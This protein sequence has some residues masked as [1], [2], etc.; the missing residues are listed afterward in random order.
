MASDEFKSADDYE[1]EKQHFCDELIAEI[2]KYEAALAKCNDSESFNSDDKQHSDPLQSYT[3]Q[4]L[5]DRINNL[6]QQIQ[7]LQ[8][9]ENERDLINDVDF[10]KAPMTPVRLMLEFF[11]PSEQLDGFK[12]VIIKAGT[13]PIQQQLAPLITNTD[14]QR[15]GFPDEAQQQL[16][17]LL[18]PDAA[19]NDVIKFLSVLT[20]FN[21]KRVRVQNV[22]LSQWNEEQIPLSFMIYTA[23][24]VMQSNEQKD[25]EIELRSELTDSDAIWVFIHFLRRFCVDNQWNGIKLEEFWNSVTENEFG[26]ALAEGVCSHFE[27]DI[28]RFTT[29]SNMLPNWYDD[30]LRRL[31]THPVELAECSVEDIVTLLTYEAS[32]DRKESEYGNE[33]I[34]GVFSRFEKSGVDGIECLTEIE[35]WKE[36]IVEWMRSEEMDGKELTEMG[37][38]DMASELSTALMPSDVTGF[39]RKTLKRALKEHLCCILNLCK[40][41]DIFQFF[42]AVTMER[43][44]EQRKLMEYRMAEE[45]RIKREAIIRTV[46]RFDALKQYMVQQHDVDEKEID[47]LQ[48]M[49][50]E[51]GYESETLL[52]SEQWM[53]SGKA[54]WSQLT[55]AQF[56]ASFFRDRERVF[57]LFFVHYDLCTCTLAL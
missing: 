37:I 32:D 44:D 8:P 56:I 27:L 46:T 19:T 2:S 15:L 36:K 48:Q 21:Q 24:R 13:L 4:Q 5:I 51:R 9:E 50:T 31:K 14:D 33:S 43:E 41:I 39:K 22:S 34:D 42:K 26:I 38:Q 57:T 11:V 18:F 55:C 49:V 1:R 54:P 47:I 20:L 10:K 30:E 28:H 53:T 6:Q 35:Q 25:N 45:Q 16:T 29:S 12:G 3:K 7:E 17:T 23:N 40:N 52:L